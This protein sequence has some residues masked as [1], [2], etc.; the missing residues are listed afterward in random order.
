MSTPPKPKPIMMISP[1][2]IKSMTVPIAS[3][4]VELM[5]IDDRIRMMEGF[6]AQRLETF[7]YGFAIESARGGENFTFVRKA[8]FAE[9]GPSQFK[10]NF[11]KSVEKTLGKTIPDESPWDTFHCVDE[12]NLRNVHLFV[13]RSKSHATE[14][15]L[16]LHGAEFRT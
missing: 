9:L 3:P 10:L 14:Y 4:V 8:I 16:R 15:F 1:T 11:K 2:M 13:F 6:K 5:Q 12:V 7:P